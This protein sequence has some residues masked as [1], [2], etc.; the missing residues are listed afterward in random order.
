MLA[1]Y[2]PTCSVVS[3]SR[4]LYRICRANPLERSHCYGLCRVKLLL[5]PWKVGGPTAISASPLIAQNHSVYI[6][7][8]SRLRVQGKLLCPAQCALGEPL[9]EAR[10]VNYLADRSRKATDAGS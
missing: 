8:L 5:T 6:R 7:D 1:P 2:N 9:Q 10:G 4:E 3:W